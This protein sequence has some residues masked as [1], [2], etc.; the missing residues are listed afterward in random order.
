M[1]AK[2]DHRQFI[3]N[4]FT[5]SPEVDAWHHNGLNENIETNNSYDSQSEQQYPWRRKTIDDEVC[6]TA[7]NSQCSS[8]A[9]VV[10]TNSRR[11]VNMVEVNMGAGHATKSGRKIR[12]RDVTPT[13]P[14]DQSSETENPSER[15]LENNQRSTFDAVLP[16]STLQHTDNARRS[17]LERSSS[18]KS[19]TTKTR[20]SKVS[21]TSSQSN[22]AGRSNSPS[23]SR[24]TVSN[25]NNKSSQ[26]NSNSSHSANAVNSFSQSTGPY[27][28]AVDSG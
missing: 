12:N 4:Y 25:S 9:E 17:S 13:E 21:T 26:G 19:A 27:A 5:R 7:N 16:H 18:S 6:L 24:R 14:Y 1:D 22:M 2:F 15:I 10:I 3:I 8:D 20:H 23:P 28:N 11:N